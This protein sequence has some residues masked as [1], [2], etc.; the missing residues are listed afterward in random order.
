MNEPLRLDLVFKNLFTPKPNSDNRG[1]KATLG[2]IFGEEIDKKDDLHLKQSEFVKYTPDISKNIADYI[3]QIDS[4]E[5]T[6][7][8]IFHIEFQNA[9][10]SLMSLRM[11]EYG[12]YIAKTN[13]NEK[14]TIIFPKQRVIYFSKNKNIKDKLTLKVVFDDDKVVDYEV[15]TVKAYEYTAQDILK[16]GM[17]LLLP[18]MLV[19]YRNELKNKEITD[20]ISRD[21]LSQINDLVE[22][23][24][25]LIIKHK[26]TQEETNVVLDSLIEISKNI[27]VNYIKKQNMDEEVE[28]IMENIKQRF[29]MPPEYMEKW[30]RDDKLIQEAEEK[31]KLYYKSK[32][33][34]MKKAQEE[35]QRKA[36]EEM[37]KAQEEAY[38][39][40]Y[41]AGKSE[42]SLLNDKYLDIDEELIK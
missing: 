12:Y 9:Y 25:E 1:L 2:A 37:K 21:F 40:G 33:E 22:K 35:A 10:D 36:Q 24:N 32:I 15:P 13:T 31:V 41:M 20:E 8:R 3:I 4:I 38:K 11:F 19:N 29:V 7:Q 18:A 39:Q 5:D 30:L 6:R 17:Y 34:E 42:S 16:N 23:T 14:D 26:V 28:N 27:N